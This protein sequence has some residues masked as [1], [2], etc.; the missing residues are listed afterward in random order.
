MLQFKE[1]QKLLKDTKLAD[2]TEKQLQDAIIGEYPISHGSSEFRRLWGRVMD[3]SGDKW[4]LDLVRIELLLDEMFMKIYSSKASKEKKRE[5]SD[6]I[7]AIH[8]FIK[9]GIEMRKDREYLQAIVNDCQSLI[10]DYEIKLRRKD[11]EIRLLKGE[12]F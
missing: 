2:L 12:D 6:K 8:N 5:Q 1:I 9:E 4:L 11:I 3:K 10:A 7:D